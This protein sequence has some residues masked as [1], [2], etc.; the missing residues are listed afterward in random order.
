MSNFCQGHKKSCG[1]CLL[2]KFFGFLSIFLQG[3]SGQKPWFISDIFQVPLYVCMC[4]LSR[5][6]QRTLATNNRD[7]FFLKI[8][9]KTFLSNIKDFLFSEHLQNIVKL[10]TY[11][12]LKLIIYFLFKKKRHRL[13][14]DENNYRIFL[15]L[16][17]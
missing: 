12:L 8:V 9:L 5:M 11:Y 7:F 4:V 13:L 6:V 15:W 1:K 17:G 16:P 14:K 10:F 3:P 2:T